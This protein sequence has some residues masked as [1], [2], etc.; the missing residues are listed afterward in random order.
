MKYGDVGICKDVVFCLVKGEKSLKKDFQGIRAGAVNYRISLVWFS[1]PLLQQTNLL[2]E[3]K[4]YSHRNKR[5]MTGYNRFY[6]YLFLFQ[7]FTC[8]KL[9]LS[10]H[11]LS[12]FSSIRNFHCCGQQGCI[13]IW[14][15]YMISFIS[16]SGSDSPTWAGSGIEV[17]TT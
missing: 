7:G 14:Y 1:N 9:L 17:I 13:W 5:H 10:I 12:T 3:I 2:R 8:W 11:Y 6:C 4:L 16:C 15:N